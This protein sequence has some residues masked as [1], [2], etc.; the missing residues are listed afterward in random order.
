MPAHRVI[1]EITPSRIE[2]AL[3]KRGGGDVVEWR[4]ERLS[5]AE[6]PSATA[7]ALT[8][9][10]PVLS[11]LVA[12]TGSAK[13][14]ATVIYSIPGAV[15]A[16]TSCPA[17][18]GSAAAEQA[19][20]LA[21][22]N[23]ADF[24][25]DDAPVDACVLLTDTSATTDSTPQLHV[26]IGADAEQRASAL[27]G[28]VQSC[29]LAV[30]RL[31]PAE[32][33]II[34][35]A[36]RAATAD[37]AR[38]GVSAIVWIGEH[39][40][41]L[42]AGV[43]GR[44]LFVRTIAAGTESLAE[45]LTRPLRPREHDAQPISLTHEAA[46]AVLLSVGV[47]APEAAVP[48]H[49]ALAGSSLLPHIQ[50]VLQRLSIEIKQSLR[51]GVPEADRASVKVSA[52]GPG[53]AVPGIL[54]AICRLCGFTHDSE[55]IDPQSEPDAIDSATGGLIAAMERSPRLTL[56]LLP[57]EVRKTAGL[58]RLRKALLT[59][60]GAAALFI[61]YEAFDS[62]AQLAAEEAQLRTLNSAAESRHAAT[63]LRE[64]AF[65]SRQALSGVEG[66]M[67]KA[68]GES[69]DYAAMLSILS[70]H[71]PQGV[72][73]TALDMQREATKSG[74]DTSR[75][76]VRGYVRLG[77]TPDP[78]GAIKRFVDQLAGYPIVESVRLG[79]TTRAQ[80]R[81]HES[82]VFDLSLTLVTLPPLQLLPSTTLSAQTAPA[83]AVTSA[84][85]PEAAP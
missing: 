81:G 37:H 26:L 32:A 44:L 3:R 51:F 53:A 46:R 83:G 16:L 54:D 36:V 59:G 24:P 10:Q 6:W 34:A 9:L 79:A 56:A 63:Q 14:G 73:L 38:E 5:R 27:A 48:G 85:Q 17:K 64:R 61:G 33:V 18:V 12:E 74:A 52:M 62:R 23:V 58:Q 77:E 65:A 71:T 82:Q 40:T 22:A 49:P 66:R 78:A 42:A 21:L 43:P 29:G 13:A 41:V 8:E 39:T 72:R 70:E 11:R 30:E 28:L 55:F 4:S 35:D 15:S 50:P 1:V 84:Q 25:V 69:P 60:I 19:A 45:A 47:P 75:V 67:R 31:V 20:R 68:L 7:H 2:V 76:S 57:S 80:V